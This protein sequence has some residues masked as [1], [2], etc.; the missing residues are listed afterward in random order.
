MQEEIAMQI[1]QRLR[2]IRKSKKV[3][4]DELARR[5]DVSKSLISQ[6]E[7]NRTIPSLLVLICLIQSLDMD[8]NE[9][10]RDIGDMAADPKVIVR[11][12]ADY[13]DFEKEPTKGFRYQRVLA[14]G[15]AGHPVDFV[16]L[17]L[18]PGADRPRLI[19]TDAFEFK[20]VITGRVEYTIGTETFLLE[21]GDS[22]FFD[23]VLPH[24]PRN[25]GTEPALMLIVYFFRETANR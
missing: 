14:K 16:L 13:K 8:I 7:N 10:F 25:P 19:R 20:Y 12:R 3:T 18:Q 21:T 23:A 9:F 11:R 17:E 6:I 22:I 2:E 1:S 5:A 24:K 15:I 4:L